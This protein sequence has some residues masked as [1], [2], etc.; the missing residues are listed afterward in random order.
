MKQIF[1]KSISAGKKIY[2]ILPIKLKYRVYREISSDILNPDP[3]IVLVDLFCAHFFLEMAAWE[4][5]KGWK[6]MN[7]LST[8]VHHHNIEKG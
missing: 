7:V 3:F 6:H 2:R 5:G 4:H 1:K 8:D